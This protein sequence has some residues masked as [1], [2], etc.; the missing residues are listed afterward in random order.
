MEPSQRFDRLDTFIEEGRIIRTKWG[1]G[2]E[3]ACLLL[4]IAPEVRSDGRVELCPAT[5]IPQW[6]ARLTPSIDDKGSIDAWFGMIKQFAAVIRRGALTLDEEGWHRVLAHLMMSVLSRLLQ[7]DSSGSCQM[8]YDLWVRELTVDKPDQDEWNKVRT[9]SAS[10]RTN[11]GSAAW[12]ATLPG[13]TTTRHYSA[14]SVASTCR[15]MITAMIWLN[16]KY[17]IRASSYA[18]E[19]WDQLT[20]ELF[21]AIELECGIKEG[22][23]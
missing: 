12:Y 19:L 5:L 14:E 1:D 4:A 8:V 18:E 20:H 7:H 10:V 11:M 17:S 16:A 13:G 23:Q 15:E 21:D 3:R 22:K 2:K 9:N 6:L